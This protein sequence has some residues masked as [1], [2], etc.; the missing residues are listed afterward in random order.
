MEETVRAVSAGTWEL[1]P[2]AWGA[3]GGGG[4]PVRYSAED[5]ADMHELYEDDVLWNESYDYE[6]AQEVEYEMVRGVTRRPVRRLLHSQHRALE[7]L[8]NSTC[9]QQSLCC[10]AALCCSRS[11]A[12]EG[13]DR[14]S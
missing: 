14:E 3:R 13:K 8:P 12:P 11:R 7:F 5:A 1:E 2:S 6:D 4:E 10:V 9:Y